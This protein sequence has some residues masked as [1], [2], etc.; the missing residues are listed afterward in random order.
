M[1]KIVEP[2]FKIKNPPKRLK[3]KHVLKKVKKSPEV[4]NDTPNLGRFVD[5]TI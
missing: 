4:K 2:V 5:I 3:D 1:I